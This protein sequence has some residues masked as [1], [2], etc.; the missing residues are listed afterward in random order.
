MLLQ[1]V[2]HGFGGVA[3][4]HL[5]EQGLGGQL[6]SEPVRLLL[7]ELLAETAKACKVSSLLMRGIG[8]HQSEVRF[9][10]PLPRHPRATPPLVLAHNHELGHLGVQT[11]HG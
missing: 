9:N 2:S 7:S 3:Q 11:A 1:L 5:D 10:S 8:H 4:H 6:G